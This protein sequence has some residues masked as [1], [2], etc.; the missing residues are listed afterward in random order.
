MPQAWWQKRTKRWY[1]ILPFQLHY[2]DTNY[3]HH[4]RAVRQAHTGKQSKWSS[5]WLTAESLPAILAWHF[6]RIP[7]ELV[8]FDDGFTAYSSNYCLLTIETRD[9]VGIHNNLFSS[10]AVDLFFKSHEE[11]GN[12]KRL[13]CLLE[14]Q[15]ADWYLDWLSRGQITWIQSSALSK[16]CK[17]VIRTEP[18]L[19]YEDHQ[20]QVESYSTLAID[21]L[22]DFPLVVKSSSGLKATS[23]MTHGDL[24]NGRGHWGMD[25]TIG[26]P[27]RPYR[28]RKWRPGEGWWFPYVSVIGSF[29]SRHS[30]ET[31]MVRQKIVL[32]PWW[33]LIY[34]RRNNE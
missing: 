24:S 3:I 30:L 21:I 4:H 17:Q 26:S 29:Q 8:A 11:G 25:P 28:G 19:P 34:T 20:I 32:F 10:V 23:L 12:Q 15:A 27:S 22:L 6:L 2:Q 31:Y 5:R 18:F 7:T 16:Q 1:I 9:P 13:I 33:L 14:A